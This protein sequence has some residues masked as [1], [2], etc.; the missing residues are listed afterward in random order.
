MRSPDDRV[1]VAMLQYVMENVFGDDE[2]ELD[3]TTDEEAL[4]QAERLNNRRSLLSGYIRLIIYSIVDMTH[5]AP[6]FAQY[7]KV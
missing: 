5:A 1:Q 6:I 7:L 2:E 3:A 4:A